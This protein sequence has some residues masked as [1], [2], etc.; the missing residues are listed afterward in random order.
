VSS[1]EIFYSSRSPLSSPTLED[2]EK[3]IKEAQN[4]RLVTKRKQRDE[5]PCDEAHEYCCQQGK[6]GDSAEIEIIKKGWLEERDEEQNNGSGMAVAG[7]Q[8]RRPQ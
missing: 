2:I 8:P 3:S 4:S 7:F 6:D 5:G 1:G